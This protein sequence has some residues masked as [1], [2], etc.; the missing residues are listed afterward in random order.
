MWAVRVMVLAFLVVVTG[1]G[2][3]DAEQAQQTTSTT[4]TTSTTTAVCGEGD[5]EAVRLRTEG[6]VELEAVLV[7]DGEVGVVLGHQLRS[8]YCSWVPFAKKLAKRHV[9]ALAINFASASPDDDMV[10]GAH[11]L[12]R[13]GVERIKLAGA[14]MGG[15][16]ALVAAA[17]I[18][19]A[20]V[21]SLSGPQVFGALDALPSVRRLDIPALFLAAQHDAT[22]AR[23][24]RT[25]Y[26]ATKSRDKALVITTGFDHGTDLLQDPRAERALL[27]FL[28]GG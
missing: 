10:A 25:L 7:G 19:A 17:Q 12:Q 20:G 11:E 3:S 18:D 8:D 15:T 13:R 22:F 4:S 21:A 16:A 26:R 27:D 24:A 23:D 1:C 5:L 28:V 6:G 14:S 9:T 2:E